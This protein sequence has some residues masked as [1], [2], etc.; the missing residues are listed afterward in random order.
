[1]LLGPETID[2][3]TGEITRDMTPV[4]PTHYMH[5][6][7]GHMLTVENPDVWVYQDEDGGRLESG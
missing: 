4:K 1:M 6:E 7:T 2:E 5:A 3:S